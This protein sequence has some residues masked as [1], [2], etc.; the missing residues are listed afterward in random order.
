MN[1]YSDS[2]VRLSY[3]E[4]PGPPG[5][6]TYEYVSS[7]SFF[8][9]IKDSAEKEEIEHHKRYATRAMN[10]EVF[11]EF[12]DDMH[13]VLDTLQRLGRDPHTR[14]AYDRLRSI[15]GKMYNV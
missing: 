15:Y 1:K 4:R 12:K 14:D 7:L 2:I 6:S 3:G 11:G 8:Q 9:M 10:E 13:I 5:Y